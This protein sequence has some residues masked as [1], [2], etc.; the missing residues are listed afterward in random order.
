MQVGQ[1]KIAILNEYLA[2]QSITYCCTVVCISHL[3]AGFS[4]TV[5]MRV[6]DHQ[7]QRAIGRLAI[8]IHSHRRPRESSV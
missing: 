1:A 7:A 6:L 5:D 4:F 2:L 8:Y 3:A